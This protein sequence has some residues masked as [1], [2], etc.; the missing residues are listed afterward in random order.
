[1]SYLQDAFKLICVTLNA[2]INIAYHE[3]RPVLWWFEVG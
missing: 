2:E 3:V 1:L